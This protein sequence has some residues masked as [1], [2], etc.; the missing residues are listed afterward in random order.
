[1]HLSSARATDS[2]VHAIVAHYE[3]VAPMIAFNFPN[4]PLIVTYYPDGLS[5]KPT[6]SGG[7]WRG[8]LPE[9]VPAVTAET[10][11]GEHVY[12][13]C[14]ENAIVWLAHHYAVGMHSWTPSVGDPESVGFARIMLRPV[15]GADQTLLKE[16]LLALRTALFE[17]AHGLEAIPLFEGPAAAALFIPLSDAPSY[18]AVRAWLKDLVNWAIS[19]HPSLLVPERHALETFTAPR[20]QCTYVS[21][22]VGHFSSLPYA[23]AGTPD[24]PMT[25][26]FEWNELGAIEHGA[27]TAAHALKRLHKGD[28]F[29]KEVAR[30]GE[31]RFADAVR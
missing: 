12:P 16:A 29:A 24:L 30:I 20:I 25:T 13:G 17:R 2:Q 9:N 3:R 14:T 21:N 11:S 19:R 23:L 4:A 22:A 31:Q 7:D 28:V 1:V 15:G 10:S 26:P 18:E 27:F 6:Y 8:R 5:G